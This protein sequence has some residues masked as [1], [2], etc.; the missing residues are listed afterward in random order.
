MGR[1]VVTMS[2]TISPSTSRVYG[3][4]RVCEVGGVAS[5]TLYAAQLSKATP[6]LRGPKPI[7]EDE[8]LLNMIQKDLYNTP[9]SGEGPKK[10]HARLKR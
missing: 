4:K 9:F 2:R 1:E 8:K 3:L 10:V 7:I 5:S 6:I